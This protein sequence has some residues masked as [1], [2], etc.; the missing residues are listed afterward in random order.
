MFGFPGP[1]G[2]RAEGSTI[3]QI[4]RSEKL[5]FAGAGGAG[6]RQGVSLALPSVPNG[7]SLGA[8]L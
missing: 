5:T 2:P 7:S 1:S 8:V 3:L 4:M 6:D